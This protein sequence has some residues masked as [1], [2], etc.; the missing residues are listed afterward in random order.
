MSTSNRFAVSVAAV[1]L[2]AV[3][4]EKHLT[5]DKSLPG[6]DQEASLEP[7][8]FKELVSSI[9]Q[10]EKALGNSVKMPTNQEKINAVVFKKSI[11]VNKPIR[12]GDIMTQDML[13]IK[14]PGN[15]LP[16]RLLPLII[17]RCVLC[18]IASDTVFDLDFITQ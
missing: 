10:V 7:G 15:G 11:V 4:I 6:P 13:I 8:E 9:R 16:A 5:L 18:D 2:G 17:G 3:I 1:L 14:R 12:K